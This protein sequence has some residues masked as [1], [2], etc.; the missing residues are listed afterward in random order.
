[1]SR[2]AADILLRLCVL[3]DDLQCSVVPG[4]DRET[5]LKPNV[6]FQQLI[7]WTDP[8]NLVNQTTSVRKDTV[9]LTFLIDVLKIFTQIEKKEIKKM[10]LTN[11]NAIFLSSEQD[12]STLKEILEYSDDIAENDTLDNVSKNALDKLRKNLNAVL[13]EINERSGTQTK[14]ENNTTNDQYS[15]ILGESFNKVSNDTMD[16]ASNI[17]NED[18]TESVK[19]TVKV[20]AVDNAIEQS[21][22]RKR[23]RSETEQNEKHNNSENSFIQNSS[24]V[25][26]NVSFVLPE[27]KADEMSVDEED[28][29]SES[30][31]DV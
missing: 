30:F 20:L 21:N 14:D 13:E 17:T 27:D 3:W 25:T 2:T 16:H 26:K 22:S 6:I 8:R 15:S 9:Q 10:I 24:V 12:Y 18:G 7:F 11:I 19:T 23:T 4:V 31:I 1:M 5:M 29:D 28:N